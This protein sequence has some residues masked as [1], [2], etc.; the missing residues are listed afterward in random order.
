MI[1][2]K[3]SLSIGVAAAALFLA[4][5]AIEGGASGAGATN[6][7][8]QE[9]GRAV[10][11]GVLHR[12]PTAHGDG[13]K[14]DV[15]IQSMGPLLDPATGSTVQVVAF[16]VVWR[17]GESRHLSEL[18][19]QRA[20]PADSNQEIREEVYGIHPTLGQPA[21]HPDP[22]PHAYRVSIRPVPGLTW[23][24]AGNGSQIL[25]DVLRLE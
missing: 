2:Y 16:S 25:F 7:P 21:G 12:Q 19:A 1:S 17:S 15:W 10:P 5:G 18:L 23:A 9:P 24:Q 11:G 6:P 20:L 22:T 8:A 3:L 14:S 4:V 13:V